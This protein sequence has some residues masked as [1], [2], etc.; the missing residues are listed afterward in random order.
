M[1]STP[2]PGAE[3]AKDRPARMLTLARDNAEFVEFDGA[4]EAAV[5]DMFAGAR[6]R[7]RHMAAVLA[8]DDPTRAELIR[9]ADAAHEIYTW[10]LTA[11]SDDDTAD[12]VAAVAQIE[13]GS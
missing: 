1:E 12:P 10:I 4:A 7:Y 13:A 2:T 3:S 6:Q 5:V 8:A 9:R 11:G